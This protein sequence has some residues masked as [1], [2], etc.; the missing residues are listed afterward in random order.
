M[1]R[2][3]Y[4]KLEG[5]ICVNAQKNENNKMYDLVSDELK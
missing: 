3:R 2:D 1:T 5:L 4:L